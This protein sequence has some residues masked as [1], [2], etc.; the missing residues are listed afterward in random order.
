[1]MRPAGVKA[2]LAGAF[3]IWLLGLSPTAL[4]ELRPG[5]AFLSEAMRATQDDPGRNPGWLWVEQ[6]A[7]LYTQ[8]PGNKRPACAACHGADPLALRG[9]A[10]RYPQRDAGDG[11]LLNLELRI[12]RCR[13]RHQDQPGFGYE[14]DELLAL[15]A[16]VAQQSR[17][18]PMQVQVTPAIA[19]D[20]KAGQ[21]F[22]TRRQGQL[23]LACTQCH[24]DLAGRK[25]RGDT[26]SNAVASGFPAYRLE[27]NRLGSLH[28]RLRACSLG[29]RA[30]QFPY[31]SLEYL[32]LELYLAV[33]AAGLPVETP[34]LR[35]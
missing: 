15:T 14:S 27:W 31:G 7:Q 30:V 11:A 4:A 19:A 6:G 21:D 34:A 18:L 5:S 10:T 12:E 3:V 28:R 16:Y 8:P 9:V 29:V 20:L 35:P 22:F 32:Q 17:G 24:D 23:N 33:R 26:I 13:S 2:G 25:L 1:M